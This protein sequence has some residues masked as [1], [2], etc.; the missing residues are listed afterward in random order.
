MTT[1]HPTPAASA[2]SSA[3]CNV[4]PGTARIATSGA[5]GSALMFAKALRPRTSRWLRLI[6]IELA[7]K[8]MLDEEA[9]DSSAEFRGQFSETPRHGDGARMQDSIDRKPRRSSVA[10]NMCG[11]QRRHQALSPFHS[12]AISKHLPLPRGKLRA[13]FSARRTSRPSSVMITLPSELLLEQDRGQSTNC[14]RLISAKSRQQRYWECA[15]NEASSED[16]R[17][18]S[19][20]AGSVLASEGGT[21]S[22]LRRT[23]QRGELG[24][25]PRMNPLPVLPQNPAVVRP[26]R[27]WDD[28]PHVG[29]RAGTG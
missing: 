22:S 2:S 24:A 29:M 20:Q 17:S 18:V 23:L 13:S 3:L 8:V 7:S 9:R 1:Q 5:D 11:M 12:F 19:V 25:H 10:A 16:A 15:K 4:F 27:G 21:A 28:A 14:K 26:R 6:R